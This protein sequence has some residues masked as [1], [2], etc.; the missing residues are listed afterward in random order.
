M[1]RI[2]DAH[3]KDW[4]ASA[5]TDGNNLAASCTIELLAAPEAVAFSVPYSRLPNSKMMFPFGWIAN[6]QI[7][8]HEGFAS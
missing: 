2:R 8:R 1:R 4:D 7:D 5:A 6:E 3:T